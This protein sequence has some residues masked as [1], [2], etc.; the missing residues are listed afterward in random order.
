VSICSSATRLMILPIV[1]QSIRVSRQV[2]VLSVLV[3]SHATRFSKSRVKPAPS[4][5]YGTPSTWTPCSGQRSRL[6]RAWTSSRQIPRS[7]WRQ[8][9]SWCCLFLAIPRQIRALR[10]LK[11]TTAQ[12][13]RDHHPARLKA[14]LADP[15]P[16]QGKQAR[17]CAR[18][19]HRRRPPGSDHLT[20]A[21][22]RS[23]PVRVAQHPPRTLQPAKKA[24]SDP[25][26]RSH[27]RPRVTYDHPRSLM[28]VAVHVVG[29]GCDCSMPGG[30]GVGVG[31]EG[32]GG[33]PGPSVR[34]P[35]R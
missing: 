16:R 9:E 4:R 2:A 7:R 18:D 31:E 19:A 27:Q 28:F 20:G 34:R 25:E 12:H 23:E 5:A 10:A 24:R 15:H 35:T 13:H 14:D 33:A 3:A 11:T 32:G 29:H 22:L 26:T 17:E 21:N 6:S 8:V 30:D 1:A